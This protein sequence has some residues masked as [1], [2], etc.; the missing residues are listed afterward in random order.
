MAIPVKTNL[1]VYQGSRYDH[2]INVTDEDI[3]WDMTSFT[4]EMH[5]RTTVATATTLFEADSNDYITVNGPG[6]YIQITIPASVS[7]A[8]TWTK[9]VYDLEI[10]SPAGYTWR[11]IEGSIKVKP[12][13]TR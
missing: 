1:T 13:V 2:R 9:G 10:T 11:L 8:W 4:A 7:A 3:L 6:G 12:E 5:V